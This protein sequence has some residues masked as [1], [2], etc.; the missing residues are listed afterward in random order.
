MKH[1][2]DVLDYASEQALASL[3]RTKGVFKESRTDP[4]NVALPPQAKHAL[5]T[6]KLAL[7]L[8]MEAWQVQKQDEPETETLFL[9][10]A[11][12]TDLTAESSLAPHGRI[13]LKWQ[14]WKRFHHSTPGQSHPT[15]LLSRLWPKKVE[16]KT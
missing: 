2:S 13:C 11:P 5:S 10:L 15:F 12:D 4:H 16:K 8:V 7:A 3:R 14:W 6:R 9:T 1:S